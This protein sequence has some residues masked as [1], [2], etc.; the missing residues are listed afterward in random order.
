MST[1]PAPAAG[2]AGTPAAATAARVP[3]SFFSMVL[4]LAGLGG[5]W[6][7]AARAYGVSP[8]LADSL[9]VASCALW[10]AIVGAQVLKLALAPEK[11]RAELEHPVKGSLASLGPTSL[12][13]L[14][15]GVA[16]HFRDLALVLFWIGAVSQLALGVWIVGGWLLAPVE[17]KHVTPA[18]YLPPV[19]GNLV[20]A[21]AASAV[22]RPDAGYLFF[23]AGVVAWLV[24]GAALLGRYLSAG[25]LPA[26]VR[27]LLGIEIAPPAVALVAWQALEGAAPDAVSGALFGFAIFQA[28]VVLRLV[29]RFRDVPFSPAYWAFTFPLAA[30]AGAA[31]RQ[32]SAAPGGIAG[33]L[34]LP[35]FVVAN[36]VVAVIVWNTLVT[37]SRGKL[38]PPA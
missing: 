30:L 7:A 38:L 24:V 19:A 4:G 11:L 9:L 21:I 31:L 6:R 1:A 12:L 29:G 10:L 25:E 17:P 15:A 16:L 3:A 37:F 22:G 26:E 36:A 14:S 18:M 33:A 32:S 28:L 2:L 35:L 23:G 27:P 13:L 34:A 20:A 5:A 8:W